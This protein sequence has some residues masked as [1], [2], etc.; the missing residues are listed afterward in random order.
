M[1]IAICDDVKKELDKIS[2]ALDAYAMAH[3]SLYLETD[4]YGKALD[5][6]DA[7]EKE[8]PYDIALL[9]ICMPGILGTDVAKEMLSRSPDTGIIFLTIS[10]EY[11]VTAFA[12]NAVHYLVK[13]FTQEQFDTALD[14]AIAKAAE[15][16]FILLS[17][18][19]GMYR[20][21]TNE[22]VYIES[23]GHYLSVHLV[24]GKDIRMRRKISSM[25]EELQ[26]YGEF[27]RIGASYIVNPGFVRKVSDNSMEMI[28][29][30]R[31][32]VPRRSAAEVRNA[33][34]DFCRREALR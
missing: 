1:R 27:M 14:R 3:P 2:S 5:I 22:V 20:I 32:S 26:K 16:S 18:V 31:I 28:N 12:L 4:R 33:Y 30:V 19:D 9:D 15:Q 10:D 23:Q 25:F 21:C 6:L 34:M 24:S 8:R 11:A 29:G 7:V 13:P 17:C